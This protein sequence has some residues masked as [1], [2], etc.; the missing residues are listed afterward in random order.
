MEKVGEQ[1][2]E[3][4]PSREGESITEELVCASGRMR[5]RVQPVCLCSGCDPNSG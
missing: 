1:H 3:I 5:P 4:G 2:V